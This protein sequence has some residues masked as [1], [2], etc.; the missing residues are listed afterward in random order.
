MR[1]EGVHHAGARRTFRIAT[2]AWRRYQGSV[3]IHEPVAPMQR[4]CRI[5]SASRR[6]GRSVA[7]AHAPKCQTETAFSLLEL[8]I[9]L[10]L[11][12]IMMVMLYGFGSRSNQ[13][14]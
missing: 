4:C 8:L 9:T 7:G 6:R 10:A 2:R 1:G 12:L 3:P 13:Q 5:L 14:R 11:I